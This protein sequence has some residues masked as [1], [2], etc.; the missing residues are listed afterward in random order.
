MKDKPKSTTKERHTMVNILGPK[1]K[2]TEIWG[3]APTASE[4]I[5]E[6]A[7][8]LKPNA[9]NEIVAAECEAIATDHVRLAQA[10]TVC[11]DEARKAKAER[12]LAN[13]ERNGMVR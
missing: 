4:L 9:P 12:S 3:S 7:V 5:Y 6:H 1:A 10:I 11:A 13:L 8:R 2:H